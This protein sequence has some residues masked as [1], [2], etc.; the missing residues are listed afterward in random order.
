MSFDFSHRWTYRDRTPEE[1]DPRLFAL[2]RQIQDRGSLQSAASEVQLS[3]RHAW[4]LIKYWTEKFGRPLA[5]FEKGRGANLTELGEKLLWADHYLS[6][7]LATDLQP[8]MTD[9]NMELTGLIGAGKNAGR[10]RIF[11][12]HGLAIAHLRSL[13][14]Q[15][16][17]RNIE[18]Q[19]RGSI[20][21]LRALSGNHCEIAGFHFPMGELARQLAPVYRKWL[22]G[23]EYQLVQVSTRQQG[24][25]FQSSN[26]QQIKGLNSL[27]RRSIQFINR[28]KESGTRV[29]FDA[30]LDMHGI[31]PA[32]INGYFDEEFTHVAVAAV[33]A[34]GSVD[35]GFG[36]KAVANRFGL[37]FIPLVSENYVLAINRSLPSSYRKEIR[38]LL[39]SDQF[40][41]TVRKLPGYDVSGSGKEVSLSDIF[42]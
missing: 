36:I 33:V 4:G 29:I 22:D 30:L 17:E 27:T 11:A 1:I 40:R 5:R 21:S 32:Q 12:S 13:L 28:Q 41:T 34:S 26:S 7:H 2:L 10:I 14:K 37:G 15:N 19:V 31:K 35:A 3:Y 16:G 8:V 23:D 6:S 24:L 38:S 9:I 42:P 18:F 25:M 39:K 20:E